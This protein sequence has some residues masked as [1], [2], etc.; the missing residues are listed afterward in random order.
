[1]I[2]QHLVLLGQGKKLY[3][4]EV[5]SLAISSVHTST[6]YLE[7]NTKDIDIKFSRNLEKLQKK[8]FQVLLLKMT[9]FC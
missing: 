6:I 1:M 7:A 5:P 4:P 2:Y 3:A 9:T 8:T